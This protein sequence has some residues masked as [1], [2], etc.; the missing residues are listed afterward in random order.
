METVDSCFQ[1]VKPLLNDVIGITKG[2]PL[3][4]NARAGLL[5]MV[6]AH[7]FGATCGAMQETS[8]DFA[9][10]TQLEVAQWT[11]GMLAS[12]MERDAAG[13]AS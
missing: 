9:N 13:S 3:P 4:E 1:K 8:A 6:T 5:L 10:S 12:L 11:A 7:F 2:A